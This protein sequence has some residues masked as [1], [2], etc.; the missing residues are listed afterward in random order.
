MFHMHTNRNSNDTNEIL[1]TNNPNLNEQY[2]KDESKNDYRDIDVFVETSLQNKCYVFSNN[3][4]ED[5]MKKK[6]DFEEQWI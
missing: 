6:C 3:D 2:S 5:L 4:F 1:N